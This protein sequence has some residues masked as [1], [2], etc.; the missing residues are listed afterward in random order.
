LIPSLKKNP[1]IHAAPMSRLSFAALLCLLIAGCWSADS[2]PSDAPTHLTATPGENRVTLRWDTQPGL[3]YWAFYKPGATVTTNDDNAVV[4]IGLGSP[5]VLA[6]LVNGTQYAFLVNGH[7]NDSKGGPPSAVVKA[8]PR[9]LSPAVPWTVG[10]P[11]TT[12]DLRDIAF[13]NNYYVAVGDAGAVFTAPHSYPDAGGVTAWSRATTLPAGATAANFVSVFYDGTRFLALAADGT[14]VITPSNTDVADWNAATTIPGVTGMHALAAGAGAYV[15]VGDGGVIERNI[16]SGA[17]GA[18]T[19]QVSGTT[20]D[21]YGV[22]Y[23]NGLFIAVG[24]GGTLLTSPDGVT[25]TARVTNVPGV[26]RHSAYGLGTGATAAT[27]VAVGDAGAIVSSPDAV[28]WTAQSLPTTQSLYS[29]VF[30][31]DLQ[32][33]AAGTNGTLAY[34]LT[35]ADG[36]WSTA[37]AG[38][39][40]LYGLAPADVFIAVGAG[41]ANVS[42]K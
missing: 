29:V 35:G 27:Y 37:S 22:S 11:F 13:G 25:W 20:Q 41:G 3:S 32:F 9:L 36:S 5:A 12:A 8:T 1:S 10:T 17:T 7:S 23:L 4:S 33:I 30:G 42:G 31:P 38:S 19:P 26:L 34:S 18:W 24:G 16:G 6:G 39:I 2:P 40:D 28:T 21:L 14:V 15:A